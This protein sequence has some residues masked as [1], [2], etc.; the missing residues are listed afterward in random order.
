MALSGLCTYEDVIAR[1][2]DVSLATATDDP[3]ATAEI[4]GRKINQAHADIE[5]DLIAQ[6]Q[7]RI[8]PFDTDGFGNTPSVIV[9]RITTEAKAFLNQT[10]VV[11]TIG[12]VLE[13]G[14]TRMRFRF[15]EA[16]TVV[17]DVL[18]RWDAMYLKEF[19]KALPLLTFDQDGNGSIT[20]FERLLMNN[21]TSKRITV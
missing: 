10:A 17:S 21:F 2:A 3:Q 15:A 9:S 4:I 1:M 12:L 14:E 16:G 19:N 20:L 11:R 6:V 7:K 8:A 13:E 5:L 18:K